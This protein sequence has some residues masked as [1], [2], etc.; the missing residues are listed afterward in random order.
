[1]C[2]AG[3]WLCGVVLTMAASTPVLAQDVLTE[4]NQAMEQ[5]TPTAEPVAKDHWRGFLGVGV[6]ALDHPVADRQA[7]LLPLVSVTYRDT[8]YLSGGSVGAWLLKSDD[9]R[10]RLGVALK[11]RSGYDPDDYDGLAGME[12]RDTSAEA[13][14]KV[15]WHTRPVNVS[16]GFFTDVSDRSKGSSASLSLSHAFRLS[17]GWSLIPSVGAEW[18]SDQV[19]D[20]YYGVLPG[21]ALPTRPAYNGTSTV[22]LRGAL[23]VHY[24]L[25]RR[26]SLFGGASYTH[27]GSGITDSPIILHDGV[28]AAFVGGGWHF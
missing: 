19:V 26:W 20:Y 16:L 6:V 14:V 2:N 11:G 12:K 9:R 24:R 22:N 27:L 25:A 5:S 28:A 8:L 3:K 23:L 21:E 4:L 1:M 7:V 18:L 10:V 15:I 13:G 17:E